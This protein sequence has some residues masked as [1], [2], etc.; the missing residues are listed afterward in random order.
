MILIHHGKDGV[1]ETPLPDTA[2]V[3]I[4]G[5]FL[6]V[7]TTSGNVVLVVPANQIIYLIGGDPE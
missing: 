6:T 7:H 5:Q 3:G 2:R 4:D 1:I